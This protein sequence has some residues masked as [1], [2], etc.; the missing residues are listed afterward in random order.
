MIW[1]TR[2]ILVVYVAATLLMLGGGFD[3]DTGPPEKWTGVVSLVLL[4]AALLGCWW[5]RKRP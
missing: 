1:I 4:S 5:P 2:I 3:E